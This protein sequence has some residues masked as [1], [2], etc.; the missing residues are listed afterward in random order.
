MENVGRVLKNGDRT[1]DEFDSQFRNDHE[2]DPV[3]PHQY[4]FSDLR[5]HNELNKIGCS[6][7]SFYFFCVESA[8][9][10]A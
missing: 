7:G 10:V 8:L 6:R 9:V 4:G 3:I 1:T 2:N 5:I